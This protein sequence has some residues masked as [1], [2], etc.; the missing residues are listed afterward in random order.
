MTV[1][2]RFAAIS[3]YFRRRRMERSKRQPL[4][5]FPYFDR[6]STRVTLQF[7]AEL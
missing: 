6:S 3:R 5:A 2:Q 1:A 7:Q 4:P